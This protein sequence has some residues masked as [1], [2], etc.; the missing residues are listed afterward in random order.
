ME[1]SAGASI[2]PV[3]SISQS[4]W[5]I[6]KLLESGDYDSVTFINFLLARVQVHYYGSND[7]KDDA[8]FLFQKSVL[9]KFRELSNESLLNRRNPPALMKRPPCTQC[10]GND[11]SLL[12]RN[13]IPRRRSS[14]FLC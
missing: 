7:A 3:L 1:M 6:Y 11:D 2:S 8:W 14:A 12:S 5:F 10:N 13:E 4:R 9:S